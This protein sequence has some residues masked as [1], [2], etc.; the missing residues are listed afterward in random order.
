M[1]HAESDL[2]QRRF[3]ELTLNVARD[4][5]GAIRLYKRLGYR[6]LKEIPGRWSYYDDQG[7]LQRVSEPGYRLIK[8]LGKG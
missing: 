7:R 6:I 8:E 5:P 3:Q 1:S 2:V 4:N